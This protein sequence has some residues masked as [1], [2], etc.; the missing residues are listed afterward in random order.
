[1]RQPFEQARQKYH[2]PIKCGLELNRPDQSGAIVTSQQRNF[3]GDQYRLADDQRTQCREHEVAEPYYVMGDEQVA[4]QRD[5]V[6]ADKKEDRRR[7][8]IAPSC[9]SRAPIPCPSPAAVPIGSVGR[10]AG[11]SQSM[12]IGLGRMRSLPDNDTDRWTERVPWP[13]CWSGRYTFSVSRPN[14]A[15]RPPFRNVSASILPKIS[16]RPAMTPVQPV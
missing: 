3:I 7:Q 1:M 5:K 12:E 11:L 6:E 14:A 15:S 16:I 10:N 8:R 9:R 4:R 2:D 13:P